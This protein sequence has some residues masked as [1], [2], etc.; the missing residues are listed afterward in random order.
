M[1]LNLGPQGDDPDINGDT[2]H[3]ADAASPSGRE[4]PERSATA[5]VTGSSIT[6]AVVPDD[7][8]S[9]TTSATASHPNRN[10]STF[11]YASSASAVTPSSGAGAAAGAGGLASSTATSSR[12]LADTMREISGSKHRALYSIP[13]VGLVGGS[14]A[15]TSG[16]GSPASAF[17]NAGTGSSCSC[18]G[19]NSGPSASAQSR[20]RT[21]WCG[22]E[23]EHEEELDELFEDSL[24]VWG[25]DVFR[26]EE[27][28]SGHP[29]VT[30]V[31][32]IFEVRRHTTRHDAT[33]HCTLH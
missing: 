33:L 8:E 30:I 17:N 27:L 1:D 7:A 10:A 14:E 2:P 25:L 20:A 15:D 19:E 6:V 29:L 28:S 31:Y 12:Q 13:S 18:I 9:A 11:T 22:L 21:Q 4:T 5:S 16:T 3:E 32:S 26:V 24:D 23:V